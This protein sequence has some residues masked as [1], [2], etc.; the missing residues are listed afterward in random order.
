M[1]NEDSPERK[2]TR[3]TQLMIGSSNKHSLHLGLVISEENNKKITLG[4]RTLAE[5]QKG[6]GYLAFC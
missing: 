1:N 5:V 6:Q 3:K 4:I 2:K